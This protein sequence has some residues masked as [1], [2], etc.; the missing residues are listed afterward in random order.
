MWRFFTPEDVLVIPEG[1][2][3]ERLEDLQN[4]QK[5]VYCVLLEQEEIARRKAEGLDYSDAALRDFR[6]QVEPFV[7]ENV[8]FLPMVVLLSMIIHF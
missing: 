2:E 8:P 4:Q 6:L 1:A 7:F 5:V 3:G